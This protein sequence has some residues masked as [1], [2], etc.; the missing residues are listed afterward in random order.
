MTSWSQSILFWIRNTWLPFW[1]SFRLQWSMIG[2][3][4]MN[5]WPTWLCQGEGTFINNIFTLKLI[6][7]QKKMWKSESNLIWSKIQITHSRSTQMIFQDADNALMSVTLFITVVEDFKNKVTCL[8]SLSM[9][10][11]YKLQTFFILMQSFF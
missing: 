1:W 8:G 10:I 4:N 5:H 9:F 3:Q 2:T 7:H 11:Y 6:F